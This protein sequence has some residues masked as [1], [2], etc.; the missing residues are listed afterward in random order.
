MTENL[1]KINNAVLWYQGLQKGYN[2]LHT[3]SEARRK[4]STRLFELADSLGGLKCGS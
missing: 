3:L 1:E 4:L 2:D